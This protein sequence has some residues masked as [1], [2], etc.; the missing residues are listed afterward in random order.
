MED[1]VD[2]VIEYLGGLAHAN[3]MAD[4]IKR[5]VAHLRDKEAMEEERKRKAFIASQ[6]KMV[7]SYVAV[8]AGDVKHLGILHEVK[9]EGSVVSYGLISTVTYGRKTWHVMSNLTY[10]YG[11]KT[12]ELTESERDLVKKIVDKYNEITDKLFDITV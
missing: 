6:E 12:R 3:N 4:M 8:Q 7:G 5:R 9:V 1:N 2:K 10:Y 11:S